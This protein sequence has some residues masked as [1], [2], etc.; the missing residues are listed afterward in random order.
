MSALATDIVTGAIFGSALTAA[1]VYQP[2]VIF[3]QMQLRSYHMLQVFLGASATSALLVHIA[4]RTNHCP[5]QTRS[6]S[7]LGRVPYIGNII[8]GL[9][10]GIGMATTGACPGTVIV[11]SALG[12][13]SGPYVACGGVLGGI[14]SVKLLPIL[15]RTFPDRAITSN[16]ATE[17]GKNEV[18][19]F[20]PTQ[21]HTVHEKYGYSINTVLFVYEVLCLGM[22]ATTTIFAPSTSAYFSPML[23]G[24]FIG[25]A[26][27][28][29]IVLS[30]KTLGVST[31]YEQIGQAFWSVASPSTGN[32]PLSYNSI[33]FALGVF[34]GA[35]ALATYI[36]ALVSAE[37]A[38]SVPRI[39]AVVGGAVMVFGARLA[40]GCT[41]GH[42]ISGMATM[43]LASFYTVAAM[44]TGG[45]SYSLL[46]S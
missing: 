27:A 42:G 36:P 20:V 25:G 46:P 23:G 12:V 4:S 14:T 43:S 28:C 39:T 35:R 8:G 15:K 21:A 31:G 26:Q 5:V 33:R 40:G 34:L 11:Q 13:S 2:S 7:S 17:N 41:S 45:I 16:K 37:A 6:P 3:S 9:M 19:K 1:G 18:K 10:I 30:R 38:V 29:S 32:G 44:F 24:L 22:I